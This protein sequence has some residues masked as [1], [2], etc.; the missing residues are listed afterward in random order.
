MIEIIIWE[1]P[2]SAK[3]SIRTGGNPYPITRK[4]PKMTQVMGRVRGQKRKKGGLAMHE[5]GVFG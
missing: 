2:F 3:T 1:C 4:L 5:G